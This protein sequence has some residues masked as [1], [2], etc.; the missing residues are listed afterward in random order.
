MTTAKKTSDSVKIETSSSAML[1][2][3]V[4]PCKAKT[5]EGM[6]DTNPLIAIH[7]YDGARKNVWSFL[8]IA[9]TRALARQLTKL[10]N[11]NDN[12]LPF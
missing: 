8:S 11:E 7:L 6:I 3:G 9:Q 2:V 5:A 1:T 4:T 12:T 10:A